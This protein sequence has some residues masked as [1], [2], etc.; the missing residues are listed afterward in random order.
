MQ[1]AIGAMVLESPHEGRDENA[2]LILYHYARTANPGE[3]FWR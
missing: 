2:E 3:S 1:E